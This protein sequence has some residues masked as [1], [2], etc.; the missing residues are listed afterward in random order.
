[1]LNYIFTPESWLVYP[2]QFSSKTVIV[3][4]EIDL[5]YASII[6]VDITNEKPMTQTREQML[7]K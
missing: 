6:P 4:I 3:P 1:M 2:V 5:W 7:R